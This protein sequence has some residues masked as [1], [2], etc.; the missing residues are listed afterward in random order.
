MDFESTDMSLY[1]QPLIMDPILNL[2]PHFLT[3]CL[4]S[5]LNWQWANVHSRANLFGAESVTD[6]ADSGLEVMAVSPHQSHFFGN[7][8]E[9]FSV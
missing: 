5:W 2:D 8:S 7:I 1:R 9:Q 3:S 4:E 6:S